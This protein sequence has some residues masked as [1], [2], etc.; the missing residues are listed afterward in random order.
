MRLKTVS[1]IGNR[2]QIIKYFPFFHYDNEMFE[3]VKMIYTGQHYDKNMKDIYFDGLSLPQPD[4]DLNK[5]NPG[6]I[7]DSLIEAVKGFD[8]VIVYGDTHSS[9]MGALAGAYNNIPVCHIEAGVRSDNMLMPEEINRKAIDSISFLKMCPS[10]GAYDNLF[11]EGNAKGSYITGDVM[12]DRLGAYLPMGRLKKNDRYLLTLHRPVN[13]DDKEKLQ[14]ILDELGKVK[15]EILFPVHP[16]TRKNIGVVPDNI[17]VVEP[18]SYISMV[19]NIYD[20]IKV[21]TD[22]GGVQK[23]AFWLTTPCITLRDETEWP[24]TLQGGWNTL[25][26]VDTL[27]ETVNR[28][29]VMSYQHQPY[30]SAQ[31]NKNIE[32]VLKRNYDKIKNYKG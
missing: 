11:A 2:P 6:E 29:F 12:F 30:G 10:K 27:L 1:I 32:D 3:P 25:A 26:T 9:L 7:L 14:K 15:G 22:S 5:Q 28:P 16:R 18:I 21:I 17:K 4:I 8:L 23:E 19:E 20:S 31:A 13:V 24:E